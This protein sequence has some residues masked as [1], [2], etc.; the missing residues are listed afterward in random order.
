MAIGI[1]AGY[2]G[3]QYSSVA[4]GNQ[5]GYTNQG[6]Y[7]I[8]IGG[9]AGVSNQGNNSIIINASG[10]Q[11]NRSIASAFFV[12]PIRADVSDAGTTGVMIYNNSTNEISYN[13]AKT[14]VIQHPIRNDSYLVHACLEGPEAGVYYRGVNSIPEDKD[15]VEIQLPEYVSAF[16]SDATPHITPVYNG[17]HRLLSISL[18]ENNSFKVYGEPGPFTWIVYAKRASINVEPKKEEVDIK[19]NG[20]YK[21][22]E[23]NYV[24]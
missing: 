23:T 7:S 1:Q 6:L 19:G 18:V 24:I 16:T 17:K 10:A 9:N 22:I 8:A 11:L 14:F 21:F 5:A 20:P 15:F 4:I 13:T 2:T 3:Q 12:S